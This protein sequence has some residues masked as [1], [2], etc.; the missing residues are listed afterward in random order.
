MIAVIIMMF[1]KGGQLTLFVI[2]AIVVVFGVVGYFVVNNIGDK[3]VEERGY[4][5]KGVSLQDDLLDCFKIVYQDSLDYVGV[6]GGYY[7]EPYGSY[8]IYGGVTVPFYFVDENVT[9]PDL[10][11]MEFEIADS[12]G[13]NLHLCVDFAKREYEGYELS[14]GDFNIE[15]EV[16]EEGVLFNNNL[17]LTVVSDD[18]NYLLDFEEMP[19]VIDSD[20]YGFYSIADYYVSS[21]FLDPDFMCMDCL[22]ELA[23]EYNISIYVLNYDEDVVLIVLSSNNGDNYPS[24][25]VFLDNYVVGDVLFGDLPQE[26][27]DEDIFKKINEELNMDVPR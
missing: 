4:N 10:E 21:R 20:F 18:E 26:G 9:F 13:Y 5:F 2:I 27:F 25:F 19:I 16:G 7:G 12:V 24:N 23:E 14:Y 6:Q 8:I 22:Y 17:E 15:V 3:D 1:D 11:F